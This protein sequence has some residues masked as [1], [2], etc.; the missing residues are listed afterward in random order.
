MRYAYSHELAV[1][2]QNHKRGTLSIEKADY[3]NVILLYCETLLQVLL[4]VYCK[5]IYQIHF[6]TILLLF[7]V[8]EVSK[9]KSAA[10]SVLMILALNGLLQKI[11]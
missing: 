2:M 6:F 9:A 8:F 4:G 3:Q 1:A 11:F 5:I 10:Q 7:Y